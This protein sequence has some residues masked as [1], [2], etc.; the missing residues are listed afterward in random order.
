[1][2]LTQNNVDPTENESVDLRHNLRVVLRNKWRILLLVLISTLLAALVVFSMTPVYK[3]TTTVMIENQQA[4][5]VSIESVYGLN[6]ASSEYYQTQFEIL[7][8]RELAE[9]V[10]KRLNLQSHAAFDPG[11]NSSS[12]DLFK[13]LPFDI[14]ADVLSEEQLFMRAVDQLEN[15]LTILPVPRT[16]LVKISFESTDRKLAAM[17]TDTLAQVFIESHLEAKLDLTR[18][19]ASWLSTRLGGLRDRLQKSERQLQDYRE[20]AG[21]VDVQGVQ[22]LSS[23]ELQQITERYVETSNLRSRA[24]TLYRQI[25]ELGQHATT[26]SLM[27][28][29]AISSDSSVA[30]FKMAQAAAK[31]AVAE[32]SKR[33]GNKHP[34][35][36]SAQ[37]ELD[38]A[39]EQLRSEVLTVAEGI[40]SAYKGA[41][42]TERTLEKQMGSAKQ[43]LQ[44]INRKE[45]K[46]IELEREVETNRQL[47]DMFLTRSRETN[48]S[49]GLQSAHARVVDPAMVPTSPIKPRKTIVLILT[50]LVSGLTGIGLAVLLDILSNTVRTP[51][52]VE[53]KLKSPMLGFLPLVKTNKSEKAYEGFL[54]D[55]KGNFAES[56]RTVR[57]SLVL[58]NLDDPHKITLIT[59]SVPSEGKSTV[60]I[61]LS[62]ALAQMET[63][64]LIDADMRRPSIGKSLG[65]PRKSPGLSNL[66]AGTASAN[67]CIH[68]IEGTSVSVMPA[69][70]IPANPLE[71]L[72]SKRFEAAL[73]KLSQHFDRIILDSAPTHSVS[74]ALVL[75]T[76]ANAVIYVV[77]S[78]STSAQLAAKGIRRL[79]DVDAPVVGVVLNQVDLDKASSYGS[80]YGDYYNNYGY[81]ESDKEKEDVDDSK[82]TPAV[83]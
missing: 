17:I 10:V 29:P 54:S 58:S 66:V 78:D 43:Q 75:S 45:F 19:A 59:S 3:A 79:R 8:S 80:Y 69:G 82:A 52:D 72:S 50:A 64:L 7:K 55:S 37:A 46:L 74:D 53:E 70:V 20:Q 68:K 41:L 67:Q 47:Y 56:I 42:Q 14:E 73:Q 39:N 77:K 48:E 15:K 76:H 30:E 33:Y 81:Y 35:M 83:G 31:R 6:S 22:T 62:E 49:E 2:E 1:M 57:T 5:V 32:L 26:E 25:V 27:S 38:T 28:I 34:R 9:R 18:T 13:Y 63:V 60:S 51:E 24:E 12:F 23:G 4:K 36:I 11:R 21:L 65:L 61:N 44:Q 71:L 16:Q 40:K